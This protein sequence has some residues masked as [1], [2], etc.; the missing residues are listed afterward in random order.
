V[1]RTTDA[2]QS[3]SGRILN[4]P[5]PIRSLLFLDA[6]TG[7]VV[8]GNYFQT[9]GGIWSTTDGGDSFTLDV[10]TGVEMKGIDWARVSADSVDVW[11]AGS[12]SPGTGKIYRTRIA[13]PQSSTAV[14]DV[15]RAPPAGAP[16][17]RVL[18]APNP[19]PHG[20][21]RFSITAPT[22]L[23]D[24]AL[25]LFDIGGR[26]IDTVG[27][28]SLPAGLTTLL[29][30]GRVAQR[31]APLTAGVYCYQLRVEGNVAATGKLIA[32]E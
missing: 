13:F 2:G 12:A 19:A 22:A 23:R 14:H 16:A 4:P 31:G 5:Y 30:D 7:F 8:G 25:A 21:L 10:D 18:A 32:V 1:H 24:C 15:E 17:V 20:T 6:T 3:W 27:L 9:I 11:C 26:R 29:W 28:G